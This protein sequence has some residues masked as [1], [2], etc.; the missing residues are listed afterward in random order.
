MQREGLPYSFFGV[1]RIL[2]FHSLQHWKVK[3]PSGTTDSDFKGDKLH[4]QLRVCSAVQFFIDTVKSVAYVFFLPFN[5]RFA[6]NGKVGFSA[7]AHEPHHNGALKFQCLLPACFLKDINTLFLKFPEKVLYFLKICISEGYSVA[8][9]K[10]KGHRCR[11]KTQGRAN[12]GQ[13][14]HQDAGGADLL[15][16]SISVDR[17]STTKSCNSDQIWIAAFFCNMGLGCGRHGFV[18]QV[19][20]AEGCFKGLGAQGFSDM[21]F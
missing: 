20:N 13:R 16:K 19:M 6:V 12:A 5:K 4:L 9:G 10:V 11:E 21:F 15:C 3:G 7:L 18:D 1:G 14:R 17:A 2:R 8:A